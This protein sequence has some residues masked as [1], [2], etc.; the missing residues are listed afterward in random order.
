MLVRPANPPLRKDHHVSA[1]TP[2]SPGRIGVIGSV[3]AAMVLLGSAA[4][5]APEDEPVPPPDPERLTL[6]TMPDG[7]DLAAWYYAS[8]TED[9]PLATVLLV[10]DLGGSHAA[11]EPLALAL[12]AG[13]CAVVAPDLRGHGKS[14]LQRLTGAAGDGD[15][16]KL[17]KR[18]DFMAMAAT[19]GGR[20]RSQSAIRGDLECVRNWLKQRADSGEVDLKK[21]YL[22]GSGLGAAVATT[23]TVA[24]A[25]WP[26]VV[27]GPQGGDV[28]G[29]VLIEPA[30]ATR[31]FSISR[32][33]AIE[34][35]R[36][37]L[38]V[39]ILSTGSSR[40]SPKVFDQFKRSRPSDWFDSRDPKK[41]PAKDTEASLF[42]LAIPARAAGGRPLSA[43]QFA[44]LQ[45]PD[46]RG[47]D[48]AA[49]IL[50]FIQAT[51]TR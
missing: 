18:N 35:I 2:R 25:A 50:T 5:A 22:V 28:R 44:S 1:K 33:L 26:P 38:P 42:F 8:P 14:P 29:I 17:L 45:S 34:P 3:V 40:D 4:G 43:D 9:G 41:S 27:S 47:F 7:V 19:A 31:G 16:S 10:H 11:I 23:W 12:Q 48:P 36:T 49:A 51:L 20:V 15:Q 13:G 39:M 46:P 21:L 6:Q 37:E 32:L 24:D 30:L